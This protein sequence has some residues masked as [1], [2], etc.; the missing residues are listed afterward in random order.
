MRQKMLALCIALALSAP[1]MHA[2]AGEID[3][4]VNKLVEKK[5]LTPS[6]ARIILDETKAEV[7]KE[8]AKGEAIS[9]P[10]WTQ[11][12]SMKGDVRF[13]TQ[14]DWGKGLGPAH[15]RTRERIRARLGIEG[16]VNDQIFGGARLVTGSS[17]DPR[18]TNITLGNGTGDFSKTFVMFDQ[19]YIRFEP[20][21]QYL[22]GTKLW[23]GKFGMPFEKTE[24]FWDGDL[25][26]EGIGLEYMSPGLRV[27]GLP[28]THLFLNGGMFWVQEIGSVDTDPMMFGGQA[29]FVS[30]IVPDWGTKLKAA[31]AYYDVTNEQDRNWTQNS[32]GTN[33]TQT[34]GDAGNNKAYRGTLKYDYN[35][36][37]VIVKLSN[38][39]L[40]GIE[41]LP[42]NGI[43]ADFLMNTAPKG[44]NTGYLLGVFLGNKKI[45]KF[46]D[47]Y[48]WGEWRY[49]GRDC[50]PDIF[51]DSDFFGFS[52]TGAPGGGGTNGQGFN[53]GL[54]FGIFK[55][56]Y[57]NLEWNWSK[58]IDEMNGTDHWYQLVQ[59]DIQVKF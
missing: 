35:M 9:A 30:K 42:K 44:K 33:S 57:V 8:M 40:F 4:L 49:L 15:T 1:A 41:G 51:P 38:D 32:A 34:V 17:A 20:H 54:Q 7:A 39:K 25:N 3:I 55:N 6:E 43:Y 45:K 2:Q 23:L 28:E 26:P 59:A 46:G 37:D 13:R 24:L 19:Y 52:P 36:V 5:I 14:V 11:R 27:E 47:W 58:P 22:N 48:A 56:T 10:D 16:K 50:V 53:L 21:Y 18:S 12:I 31:I 29:G